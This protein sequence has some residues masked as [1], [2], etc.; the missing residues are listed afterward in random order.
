M[1][2]KALFYSTR[3]GKKYRLPEG[4]LV[5]LKP[6]RRVEV[7]IKGAPVIF[8]FSNVKAFEDELYKSGMFG[9]CVLVS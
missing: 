3:E 2:N 9:L 4:G 5:I 8:N 6:D 1:K 7:K